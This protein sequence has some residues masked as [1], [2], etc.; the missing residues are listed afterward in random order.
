MASQDNDLLRAMACTGH[1]GR[2]APICFTHQ[3]YVRPASKVPVAA[4]L[5]R[6]WATPSQST[7]TRR[8]ASRVLLIDPMLLLKT[9][10]LPEGSD[11][12]DEIKSDG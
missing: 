12:L 3:S 6:T 10:A 5:L 7:A 8:R 2:L 11:V 1:F 4:G 9:E